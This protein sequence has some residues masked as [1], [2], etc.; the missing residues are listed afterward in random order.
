MGS[1][2]APLWDRSPTSAPRPRQPRDGTGSCGSQPAHQSMI[3]RRLQLPPPAMRDR[4]AD[5]SLPNRSGDEH[6]RLR[7]LKRDM[8]VDRF[9]RLIPF[10]M[11]GMPTG[12]PAKEGTICQMRSIRVVRLEQIVPSPWLAEPTIQRQQLPA[13]RHLPPASD[14]QY[15]YLTLLNV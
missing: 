14:H 8:R 11:A 10:A 6:S 12:E 3:D 15:R 4:R 13:G 5:A 2:R 9:Q 1:P 7:T